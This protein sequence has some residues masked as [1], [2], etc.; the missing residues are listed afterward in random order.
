MTALKTIAILGCLLIAASALSQS[1]ED[2]LVS[3]FVKRT[4]DK[5]TQ[6]LSWASVS[7]QMDRINRHNDYNSFATYES[8]NFTNA[9]LSWLGQAKSFG[10]DMGIVY[11]RRLAVSVGGEYWLKLGDNLSGDFEYNS[12]GLVTTVTDPASQI[13]VWGVTTGLQYYPFAHPTSS[14]GTGRL[15]LRFGGTVGYYHASWNVWNEYQS[16]NLTTSL[17]EGDN[18]SFQDSGPGFSLVIGAD[19][20]L[21]WKSLAV[22]AEFGYLYLNFDNIAWYNS[23]EQ[24]IV[25][26]SNGTPKGRVDL[27]LSGIRAKIELKRFFSW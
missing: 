12:S 3:Q 10:I 14:G 6:K 20:P 11:S 8:A 2:Q 27:N 25:A 17:P 1:A 5:R 13:S 23:S 24:E 21:R 7:F 9:N 4:E 16:L 26:S 22:G 15:S 18:I 19:Y